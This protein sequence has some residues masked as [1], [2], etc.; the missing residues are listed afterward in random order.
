MIDKRYLKD[1]LIYNEN[2]GNDVFLKEYF[3]LKQKKV[4]SNIDTLYYSLDSDVDWNLSKRVSKLVDYLQKNRDSLDKSFDEFVIL[5]LDSKK[6][7]KMRNVGFSIYRYGIEITD[8]F[9]VFIAKSIPNSKTPPLIV[10]LRSQYLWL[11]GERRAVI[12]SYSAILE[13][14][15]FFDIGLLQAKLNRV[16]FAYHT[17]IIKNMTKFFKE[18]DLNKMQVSRFKR[19]GSQG[20]FVG[21][22]EVEKDYLSLG[23]RTSNNFFV[24]IY[25]KNQEVVNQGYKQF[26]LKLWLMNGLINRY[27]FV[28]LEKC[29]INGT[30]DYLDR[31]RLE[32]YLEHGKVEAYKKEIRNILYSN[33]KFEYDYISALANKLIPHVTTVFN[34]EYQT[35]RKLYHGLETCINL[36]KC[37]K[38]IYSVLNKEILRILDNKNLLHDYL[39]TDVLRFIDTKKIKNYSRKRDI[40]VASWWKR[41]QD[42]KMVYRDDNGCTK[43]QREYQKNLDVEKIKKNVLN[44]LSVLSIYKNGLNE[45]DLLFDSLDFINNLNESDLQK[46]FTYKSKKL[47][48]LENRILDTNFSYRKKNKFD[49]INSITGE[50]LK[51]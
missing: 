46:A 12:E 18:E 22:W 27:D 45:N 26:F 10:Q 9:I 14:L 29:F 6:E 44:S 11:R 17:N 43:L 4:V 20:R 28:C 8:E 7:L 3:D 41:I 35:K 1:K 13:M 32:F 21:D 49:L 31:S 30:Y 25:N 50:V 23:K 51:N 39:T 16:D 33:K 38:S 19:F 2:V 42:L 24:R 36:L 5:D 34:I 40:P 48:L 47:H 37:N 15:S